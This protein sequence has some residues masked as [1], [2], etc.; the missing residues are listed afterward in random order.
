M[1]L[2]FD[3]DPERRSLDHWRE[4]LISALGKSAAATNAKESKCSKPAA[5]DCVG[6]TIQTADDT[7]FVFSDVRWQP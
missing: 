6:N 7:T 2:F 5:A 4:R 3:E 1:W